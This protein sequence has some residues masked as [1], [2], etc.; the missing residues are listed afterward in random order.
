MFQVFPGV[1]EMDRPPNIYTLIDKNNC[2][3]LQDLKILYSTI[4]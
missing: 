3:G 1:M 4:K 2:Q